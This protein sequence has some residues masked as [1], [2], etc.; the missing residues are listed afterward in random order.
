MS[1]ID[2]GEIESFLRTLTNSNADAK[3]V[4]RDFQR[5]INSYV[6]D[7]SLTGQ[8]I[9]ASKAYFETGYGRLCDAVLQAMDESE[10]LLSKY[11]QD[12]YN[13]VSSAS[14]TRID[15]DVLQQVAQEVQTLKRKKEELQQSLSIGTATLHQGQVQKFSM[16]LYDAMEEEQI[17]EKYLAFEQSHAHF[18]ESFGTLVHA[19]Q[20][21]IDQILHQVNFSSQTGVYSFSIGFLPAMKDLNKE[22]QKARKINPKLEQELDNYQV[23]AMVY[24]GKNGEPQIMWLLEKNGVGVSNSELNQYLNRCG[25][26]LD[27]SK[28]SIITS[29]E[30]NRKINKAWED[31]VYYLTGEVYSGATGSILKA[32]AHVEEWKGKLDESGL[33]DAVLGLGLSTAAIMYKNDISSF[34]NMS[35]EDGIRY[36][37]YWKDV[38]KNSSNQQSELY[39]LNLQVVGKQEYSFDT[40]NADP[41][42]V[43]YGSGKN[44]NP[45]EWNETI[46]NLKNQN[47]EVVMKENGT[48]GYAPKTDFQ[49][50]QLNIDSKSSYSALIHE[51]QH[52][53]DDAAQGFK[54]NAFNFQIKNRV[55]LEF[56]AYM[57]EIQIAERTGNRQLANQ[58]FENYIRERN[59]IIFGQSLH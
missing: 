56:N 57:K 1:R 16:E 26:Y 30:L 15:A 44:S 14:D 37:Q 24:K 9:D 34:G 55:Q 10:Q 25:K 46:N 22:L 32:S 51:Q 31:G 53:L 5:T 28:Y 8:A 49:Q 11:I 59:Q 13:Q 23:L 33:Y 45:V 3:I 41:A 47:V 4:L 43:V 42:R 35:S 27:A 17:L 2:I 12:F 48:M 18:F 58:L 7:K 38:A 6:G 52:Y 40:Y 21:A 39:N 36:N 29:D 50:P 20:R 54:G 19:I